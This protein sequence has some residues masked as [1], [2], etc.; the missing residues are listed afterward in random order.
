M[1]R[2]RLLRQLGAS[3]EHPVAA[4]LEPRPQVIREMSEEDFGKL[5][6]RYWPLLLH[7]GRG[8]FRIPESDAEPLIHEVFLS[9]LKQSTRV[10]NV[11]TWLVLAMCNASRHYWRH[12]RGL[13]GIEDLPE[14]DW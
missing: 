6:E 10:E 11:R 4:L 5:Y 13:G 1:R 7:V 8:K 2:A 3:L 9:F 14:D 12:R